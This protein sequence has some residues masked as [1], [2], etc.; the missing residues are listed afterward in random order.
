MKKVA[1]LGGGVAG[2]SAAH[3]LVERGFDVTVYESKTIPGGKARSIPVPYSGTNGRKNLPGEHGFRCFPGFYRHII[4]TM[5]R[6][7]YDQKQSVHDQLVTA[8]EMG[9]A[10]FDHELVAI[11]TSIPKSMTGIKKNLKA[12]F[13]SD[14]GLNEEEVV[15]FTERLWQV[16]TS[17]RERIMDEYERISWWD[18]LDGDNQSKNFH[19]VFAAIS[20]SLV[21]AKSTEASTKTFGT[22]L[23]QLLIGILTPTN[24]SDRVL[25]GPTNEVWIDPWIS[26]LKQ[27]GVHYYTNAPVRGFQLKEGKITGV[28]ID[29]SGKDEFVNADFY[30]STLPVEAMAPLVSA[31]MLRADPALI[32]LKKLTK[33]VDWMNGLQFFMKRDVPIVNGHLIIMDSPW[34]ITAISQKQF[35]DGKDLQAYGDGQVR[36]IIS[37]DISEWNQ[38]GMLLGK[39]AIQ[40]TKEEIKE[41]VWAQLK[42][43]L[44]HEKVLLRDEDVHSWFLDPDIHFDDSGK[45][46]NSEPLLINKVFAWS[47]RPYAFT[48]IPNLFLASDYV[49]TNTDLA[50]MEAANEAARRAVN[51]ILD[52]ADS[53]K[54]KCKIWDMYKFDLLTPWHI[55]DWIRYRKG[56]PWNGGSSFCSRVVYL[57]LYAGKYAWGKVQQSRWF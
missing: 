44:N 26:Y 2:L 25:N 29:R 10:R 16:M 4:D 20:R 19:E 32:G 41:E 1:I 45:M 17:C 56:L 12:L 13:D 24:D 49:R 55:H 11:S 36:G 54:R 47:L 9:L 35:W 7:P 31:D 23:S 27:K 51:S 33:D 5:K 28:H 6:I 30:V 53:K 8:R 34:A 22:V 38:P 40:C 52:A 48:K 3:E 15:F 39:K 43:A 37:V 21:A 18:Y 50:S 14:W 57:L 46:I 42:K